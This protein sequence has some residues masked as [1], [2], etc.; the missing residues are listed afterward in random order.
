MLGRKEVAAELL[1]RRQAR[2]ELLAYIRYT[3]PGYH[4]SDFSRIVCAALDKFVRDVEAGLRPI[5]ILQAPPQHGKSEIVS[6]KLPPYLAGTRPHLRIA[7]ASYSSTLAD[8][9]S[10]DVRRNLVDPRHL[11]L[12][13]APPEKRKYA[14]DRNGEFSFPNGPGSY[15]GDGVGGG[16]TGRPADIFIIDDPIKNA[17]E[18]LS[19]TTKEG[20]WNWYQSTC[21][22]RM[23]KNSGQII[24]ATS[25]AEDDLSGRI[26]KLHEGDQRLTVLRF[27]AINLPTETGYNPQLP[28][29]ALIPALHPLEQLHEFKAELSDYWWSA[30]Y[31][32]SPKSLGGNVFKDSGVRYYLTKD[33]P[34]KFD[35]V[36][37]SW[38]CTFKD[39]D[40]TDFVVGQ[41]WGKK[42]ADAYLLFQ[43][44]ERMSFTATVKA[45]D[46]V[47]VA[48]PQSRRILI[49]DKANGPAV[50][51]TLK[52]YV[53]GIL[54]VEPD[55]SK[56][57]RAHAVT[58]Y[59]EAGNVW[60]PH[61]DIAAAC[62][63]GVGGIK[64]FIAELTTFPA[65]ANDDQVDAMSQALR[66][67]YPLTGR[68]AVSQA[69]LEAA[70]GR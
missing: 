15:I 70:M 29:G 24:M 14:I 4:E 10:L 58:S 27:P 13:P 69:A 22:T 66:D 32:S 42:G 53:P 51:D 33:L 43:H 36:V 49:E 54:P 34:K 3:T 68:I 1:R 12:F 39:T 7:A 48:W 17:Q 64:E 52:K 25:W 44:R 18:A 31:Q 26:M 30:M 67:L 38:D 9:M 19:P 11:R 62:F 65:A 2:R 61:P 45:V 56:L 23:S 50:I 37:T 40:G 47:H 20:H 55:G 28:E 8:A 46:G 41:V 5:L 21:K 16:F 6:R 35:R 60:L 59:W 57:A 63:R